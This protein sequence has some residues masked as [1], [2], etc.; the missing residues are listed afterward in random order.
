MLDI[1]PTP[2][3][4][5][6]VRKSINLY[7]NPGWVSR[8]SKRHKLLSKVNNDTFNTLTLAQPHTKHTHTQVAATGKK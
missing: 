8:G 1:N 4:N 7:K 5:K 6:Q 3:N 2:V